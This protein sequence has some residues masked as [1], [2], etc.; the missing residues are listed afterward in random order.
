M[1]NARIASILFGLAAACVLIALAWYQAHG[2]RMILS[3]SGAIAAV[4]MVLALTR[5]I[6]A[7][8]RC[9]SKESCATRHCRIR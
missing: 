8:I 7:L 5:F 9:M 3:T 1:S 6:P 2:G 4:V